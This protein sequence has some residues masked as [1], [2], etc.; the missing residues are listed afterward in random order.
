MR[1]TVRVAAKVNRLFDT[2]S[3]YLVPVM[4]AIISIGFLAFKSNIYVPAGEASVRFRAIEQLEDT[5]EPNVARDLLAQAPMQASASTRLSERPFWVRFTTPS[6]QTLADPVI[7]FPSRH[8]RDISCWNNDTLAVLGEASR[9]QT[10]GGLTAVRAGFAI[11]VSDIPFTPEILCRVVSSGPAVLTIVAWPHA[12]LAKATRAFHHGVGL[13]E[14]GLITLSLF[15]LVTALINRESRYVLFAVWLIGNLRLGALSM[16]WDTQWLERTIAPEWMPSVRMISMAFYYIVTYTLFTQFFKKELKLIGY[17]WLLPVVQFL[18]IVLLVL[19][20]TLP[21]AAFLP[22]MWGIVAVGVASLVFYLAR[23]LILTR[24]RIAMW[25]GAALALVL[26]ATF[27]EVIAAAFDFKMIVSSFN[28]VTAALASSLMAGFAFAEQMRQEKQEKMWAQAELDRTYQVTPAGLFTLAMDGVFLRMNPALRQQLAIPRTPLKKWQW[29]EFFAEGAWDALQKLVARQPDGEMEVAGLPD[30][31]GEPKWYLVR[32]TQADKRIEGSLQDITERVKVTRR[33]QFL[34]NND[35]LTGA[36]NRRGIEEKLDAAIADCSTD[37]SLMVAYLDLDRFKLINDLYGHQAG[38]EVLKQVCARMKKVLHPL[39]SIGRMGGDE[40][41]VVFPRTSVETATEICAT[42]LKEIDSRPYQLKHQAFQV[43]ISIGLIETSAAMAAKDAISAADRASREAKRG[44]H[45]HVVVYRKNA[46]EFSERAEELRLIEQL[47]ST[48]SPAGFFLEMQPIMSLRDPYGNHNFEVLLRM[49]D[50]RGDRLPP[51]RI[52]AAVEASGNI[53]ELDKWVLSTTL[54]WLTEHIEELPNT[55]FVCVNLSGAS[56]NDEAFMDDIFVILAR[57][58]PV[59]PYLCIE[60]TESV[61]LHDLENS[62]RFIDR[63]RDKGAKI[64]LDDFGAGYTSFSYLKELAADALKIDGSFV[65]DMHK[66]PANYSIVEAIV[67]LARNLGMRSIAEWTEDSETVESLA[68][69][70]V[71]YVQGYVV[72]R[73]QSPEAIL[74]ATSSAQFV[75]DERLLQFLQER[76]TD[77]YGQV[78]VQAASAHPEGG[79]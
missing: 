27:S 61:A 62:R 52:I 22:W 43:R 25:Y 63:L 73:P 17:R 38:D 58:E 2:M 37:Q 55:R 26:L 69:M 65:R 39:H 56:L 47:G 31:S 35:S 64:A 42:I 51:D 30:A 74:A 33:L 59:L 60:V 3:Y 34:A 66:H 44:T 76:S 77:S 18:G 50:S 79:A 23:I 46:R 75:T 9:D 11:H 68:A 15:T 10:S 7:E 32:A 70:G 13:L 14:G 1:G 67:E 48:F 78:I 28:S 45:G 8:A 72:A 24:S 40:F 57:F 12:E 19:A 71:D 21:Y 53:G 20:L 54:V 5:L 6:P 29:R 49:L 41:L 36:L 4:I 16:G